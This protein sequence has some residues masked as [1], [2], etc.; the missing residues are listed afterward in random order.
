M[1]L[2]SRPELHLEAL[3][4]AKRAHPSVPLVVVINPCS[5]PG[6]E[7]D[8]D[9]A[10]CA[11]SLSEAGICVAGYVPTRYGRVSE[12]QAK[13]WID[14]YRRWYDVD[15]VFLDEM[16]N[17]PGDEGYYRDLGA[18]SR[19]VG[20]T[21][22]IGN[23]GRPLPSSFAGTLDTLVVAEGPGLL[24]PAYVSRVAPEARSAGVIMYSVH[25]LSQS[26]VDLLARDLDYLY[27]TDRGSPDPYQA[28]SGFFDA[29]V[30]MAARAN[31]ESPTDEVLVSIVAMDRAGAPLD[32]VKFSGAS[33]GGE[34]LE[35]PAP[36]TIRARAGDPWR[37][38]PVGGGEFELDHWATGETSGRI[39]LAPQESRVLGAYFR[40][41]AP[42]SRPG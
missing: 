14:D 1:P 22:S 31:G 17:G 23:P 33:V 2:Y 27:A 42:V 3:T 20:V 5:G 39:T 34:P 38:E 36:F 9:V 8:G 15:A 25:A 16:S 6:E 10:G 7:R 41:K 13:S 32:G 28:L 12:R 37:V 30:S 40:K 26:Y 4:S 21:L 35:G 11:A 18:F 29:L 24:A 19:S